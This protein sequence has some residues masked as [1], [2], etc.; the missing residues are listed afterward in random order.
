M[1]AMSGI[2]EER[3]EKINQEQHEAILGRTTNFPFP[4]LGKR[5]NLPDLGA[6]FREN[7]VSKVPAL[8]F[9]GTL[10][11]RTYLPAAKTLIKGFANASHIILDGAGHDLF[12]STSQVETLMLQFFNGGIVKSKTIALGMPEWVLPASGE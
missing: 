2:S 5:L 10:D 1:D 6:A 11:G 4:D 12:M 8:F 9:S 7:P 3:W